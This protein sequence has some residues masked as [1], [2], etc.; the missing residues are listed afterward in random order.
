MDPT[1]SPSRD[2]SWLKRKPEE[3]LDLVLLA[4]VFAVTEKRSAGMFGSY[5]IG[6]LAADGGFVDV[7]D[8]AGVDRARDADIQAD[9]LREGLLTGRRV[10]RASA[11]GVRPGVEFR[12]HIIVTVRF[13]GIIKDT[14]TGEFKMR[15]PKLVAIRGDKG[16][17]EANSVKDLEEIYLRQ[18][19]G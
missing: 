12:P 11:S 4:G 1:C 9:V 3:T 16:P 15:D 17:G 5:A 14:A 18:R 6:A 19:V 10:E 7:G 2:P 13:E 8:V